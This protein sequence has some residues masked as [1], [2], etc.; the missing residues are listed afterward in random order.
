MSDLTK[1]SDE[2]LFEEIKAIIVKLFEVEPEKVV[3]NANLFTDLDL[4]S[5]DA[6]DMIVQLQKKIGR[7]VNPTVFK[8]VKT[9][10]D[11]VQA[12]AALIRTPQA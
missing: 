10:A 3:L 8:Q 4:D 5:I 7:K 9:V 6:V 12:V 1:M 11:V 2:A